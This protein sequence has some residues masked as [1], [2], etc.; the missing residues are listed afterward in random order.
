MADLRGKVSDVDD[1]GKTFLVQ[2]GFGTHYRQYISVA[3]IGGPV[4]VL[5][6]LGMETCICLAP[7]LIRI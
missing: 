5:F 1:G 3:V 6:L 2:C 7:P 4:T